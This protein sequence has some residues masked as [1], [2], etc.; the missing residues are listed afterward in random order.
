MNQHVYGHSLRDHID[1]AKVNQEIALLNALISPELLS[2]WHK[3]GNEDDPTG[4]H[5]RVPDRWCEVFQLDTKQELRLLPQLVQLIFTAVPSN[6]VNVKMMN[7]FEDAEHFWNCEVKLN[8]LQGVDWARLR[9]G[10]M[11]R[12]NFGQLTM[13]EIVI[14]NF[15]SNNNI[16]LIE[17][18]PKGSISEVNAEE[19]D[20]SKEVH[21]KLKKSHRNSKKSRKS[22]GKSRN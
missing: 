17:G 2:G 22:K 5:T 3:V 6:T 10:L 19:E 11:M 14:S 18:F 13:Q 21:S 20:E 1:P 4:P 12:H 16:P 15:D 7:I 8:G 9:T